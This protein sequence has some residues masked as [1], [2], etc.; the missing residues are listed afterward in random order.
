[1]PELR[2]DPRSNERRRRRVGG[3][4]AEDV[5]KKSEGA[6]MPAREGGSL[7]ASTATDEEDWERAYERIQASLRG[8]VSLTSLDLSSPLMTADFVVR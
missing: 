6:E 3:A 4:L 8:C 2:L 1:M 5:E 7:S